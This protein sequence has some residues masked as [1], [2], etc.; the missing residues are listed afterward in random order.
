M[1]IAAIEGATTIYS[2]DEDIAMLAEGRFG[3]INIAAIPL[4][5]ESAQGKLP[6]EAEEQDGSISQS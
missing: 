6:F 2:D 4:P 1:A 3:V 5:P